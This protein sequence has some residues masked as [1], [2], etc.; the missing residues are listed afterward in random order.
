M[1]RSAQALRAEEGFTLVELLMAIVLISLA[2]LALMGTFDQS[3]RT[4]N[5]AEAQDVAVQAA[6]RELERVRSLGYS[7]I[8]LRSA[9]VT[10]L[11]PNN[12]NFEVTNTTPAAY[13]WDQSAGATGTEPLVVNASGGV[14]N[15]AGTWGSATGLGGRL[16]DFVTQ[17]DDPCTACSSSQDQAIT[18]DYKRITVAASVNPPSELKKPILISTIV[19]DR[20]ARQGP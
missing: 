5:A 2:V 7:A 4:T 19:S 8:A 18:A 13:R 15:L 1:D 14:D 3:R 20:N 12:P 10:S 9:P 11:D 6:E 17:V 16:Y